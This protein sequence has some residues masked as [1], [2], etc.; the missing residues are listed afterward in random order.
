M[1]KNLTMTNASLLDIICATYNYSDALLSINILTRQ[2][3]TGNN[4]IWEYLSQCMLRNDSSRF[5]VVFQNIINLKMECQNIK[6]N[7]NL[8][9]SSLLDYNS[10]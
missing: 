3:V 10:V 6:D 2:K 1:F 8:K 4:C 5:Y 7:S 9:V